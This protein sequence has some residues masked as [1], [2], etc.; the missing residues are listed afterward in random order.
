MIALCII[1]LLLPSFLH[2]AADWLYLMWII[3]LSSIDF[4][5]F[6]DL[7][8]PTVRLDSNL[9][10]WASFLAVG[11][12]LVCHGPLP[13]YTMLKKC[14]I[15]VVSLRTRKLEQVHQEL[16]HTRETKVL[17]N[18]R[19][20]QLSWPLSRF[21]WS[22]CARLFWVLL[23]IDTLLTYDFIIVLFE[24]FH[25]FLVCFMFFHSLSNYTLHECIN[26]SSFSSVE[27]FE[28]RSQFFQME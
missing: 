2:A 8:A 25:C 3:K 12:R 7:H 1:F 15:V 28:W 23:S 9:I 4:F 27:N 17:Y 26:Y 22:Q 5:H 18:K 16:K 13:K 21:I 14:W 20:Y 11:W 10:Y 6:R 19:F 24:I